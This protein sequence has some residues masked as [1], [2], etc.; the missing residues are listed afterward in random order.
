MTPLAHSLALVLASMAFGLTVSMPLSAPVDVSGSRDGLLL[1]LDRQSLPNP[2]FVW[3][4]TVASG[5]AAFDTSKVWMADAAEFLRSE[6]AKLHCCLTDNFLEAAM[7]YKRAAELRLADDPSALRDLRLAAYFYYYSGQLKYAFNNM[8]RV[9][10]IARERGATR[11][12][13]QAFLEAAHI[14]RKSGD[15]ERA[16]ELLLSSEQLLLLLPQNTGREQ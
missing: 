13:A 10:A 3:R 9:G 4:D 8:A 6:A 1:V 12:A 7:L 16:R 15:I 11:M 5:R 2:D 14:A